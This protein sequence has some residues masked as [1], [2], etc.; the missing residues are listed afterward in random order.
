MN[1]SKLALN[2]L[3]EL[4]LAAIEASKEADKAAVF[5]AVHI[6]VS[7]L[8]EHV[9]GYLGENLERIRWSIS[10]ILGY[11]I[12]NGHSRDQHL[13]W[14]L[15]AIEELKRVPTEIMQ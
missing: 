9:P 11:D 2:K 3:G 8:E 10:A 12:D 6:L 15:A 4:G 13:T 1:D 5:A 7:G 14:A